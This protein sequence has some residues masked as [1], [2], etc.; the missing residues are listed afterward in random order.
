MVEIEPSHKL[1]QS[2]ECLEI[3]KKELRSLSQCFL[4]ELAEEI[5]EDICSH[6][7]AHLPLPY[8]LEVNLLR[9]LYSKA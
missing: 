8:G 2:S 1:L 3:H 7:F 9:Y 4:S 5:E 6:P